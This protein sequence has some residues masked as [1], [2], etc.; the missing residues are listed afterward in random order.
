MLYAGKDLSVIADAD[1]N[2]VVSVREGGK[3][4]LREAR[5]YADM[6]NR[7]PNKIDTKFATASAGKVFAAAGILRLIETGI[8]HFDDTI[9]AILDFDLKAIDRNITIKQLL[10]HTSGIPDY[11]DETVMDEYAELWTDFPNYRIRRSVD[12]LPLFI[13]KPMMYPAG[14]R[15]QYNNSGFVMLGLIIEQIA[16]VPFDEYL[17]ETI[18]KPCGMPHTGYYELDRLPPNC[19]NSYIYDEQR[20]G[21]YTNIYSVDVKGTGAGGAFTTIADVE[22][23]WGHLLGGTVL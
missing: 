18:F 15:F 12:L 9:G 2:G 7:I 16:H 4:L 8:L 6:A 20:K 1:F 23:F 14:E 5:G 17:A 19:A 10:T 13:N 22:N 21:Y 11:F 3:V